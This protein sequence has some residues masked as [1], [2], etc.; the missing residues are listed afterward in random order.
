MQDA[1]KNLVSVAK[2]EQAPD[3][4]PKNSF[5][6][7]VKVESIFNFLAYLVGVD[8]L[9]IKP[10]PQKSNNEQSVMEPIKSK[11]GDLLGS[12]LN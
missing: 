6:D 11:K 5:I 1:W 7:T 4:K 8:S 2:L 12:T 10:A 9:L 3:F